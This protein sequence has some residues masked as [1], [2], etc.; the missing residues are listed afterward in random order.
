MRKVRV[1]K[2][3]AGRKWAACEGIEDN[4]L[5]VAAEEI[6]NGHVEADLGGC[7]YKKRLPRRGK[8]SYGWAA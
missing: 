8:R 3:K 1:F 5:W 4:T 2:N 6:I 7:L